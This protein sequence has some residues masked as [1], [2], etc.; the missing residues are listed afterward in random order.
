M[1]PHCEVEEQPS[2]KPKKRFN[3]QNARREDKGGVAI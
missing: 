2:K 1:F 3:S